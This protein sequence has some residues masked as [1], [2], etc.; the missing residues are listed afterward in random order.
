MNEELDILALRLDDLA[1]GLAPE[2]DLLAVSLLQVLLVPLL[3]LQ[4]EDHELLV[5]LLL[6]LD[7]V[8]NGV[9]SLLRL[10]VKVW[11]LLRA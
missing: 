2:F 5:Q 10:L 6:D 4:H 11:R 9:A 8:F 7:C 3:Y 1:E